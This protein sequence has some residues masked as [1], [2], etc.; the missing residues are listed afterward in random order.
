VSLRVPPIIP[1]DPLLTLARGTH[2]CC[3][4]LFVIVGIIVLQFV[5][6]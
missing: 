2:R 3:F 5:Q 4:K 6:R 1:E